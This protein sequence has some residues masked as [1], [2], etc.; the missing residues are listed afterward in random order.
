MGTTP[1]PAVG[2]PTAPPV[3]TA[4]VATGTITKIAGPMT[5]AAYDALASPASDTLFVI[6]G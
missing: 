6:S 3:D 2:V 5:Q 4:V 1:A